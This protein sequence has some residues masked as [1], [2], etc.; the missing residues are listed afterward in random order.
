MAAAR[1][2]L[3]YLAGGAPCVW[4][5]DAVTCE[6]RKLLHAYQNA[7]CGVTATTNSLKGY[8]NQFA[9][10]AGSRGLHLERTQEWIRQQRN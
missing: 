10:R 3:V 1:I 6:R 7:V 9:I 2:A 8:L 4:L 5:P